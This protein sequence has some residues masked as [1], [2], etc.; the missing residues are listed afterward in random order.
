MN[1]LH[2][3]SKIFGE[4]FHVINSFFYFWLFGKILEEMIES[5]YYFGFI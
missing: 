5:L 4:L 2:L 1:A 3:V